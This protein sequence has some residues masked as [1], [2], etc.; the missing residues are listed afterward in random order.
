MDMRV[1]ITTLSFLEDG[2][3]YTCWG[4]MVIWKLLP[5]LLCILPLTFFLSVQM[6][7][8]FELD[9]RPCPY[10]SARG[11]SKPTGTDFYTFIQ[12]GEWS[13]GWGSSVYRRIFKTDQPL[14]RA[15]EDGLQGMEQFTVGTIPPESVNNVFLREGIWS[16]A[17]FLSWR[18]FA[19]SFLHVW[20]ITFSQLPLIIQTRCFM[21]R[22][23]IK[24]KSSVT[25][26][27]KLEENNKLSSL[28]IVTLQSP[29]SI[30]SIQLVL[31]SMS[32]AVSIFENWSKSILVVFTLSFFCFFF[33]FFFP[34]FLE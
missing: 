32:A 8:T 20:L 1:H 16:G 19:I 34:F 28:V 11:I 27:H 30:F 14:E 4:F 23:S 21:T 2:M 17:T 3:V 29:Q 18:R 22:N 13:W 26:S 7:F 6:A 10:I 33:C 24:D 25:K 9:L 31:H 12:N 15:I 5:L